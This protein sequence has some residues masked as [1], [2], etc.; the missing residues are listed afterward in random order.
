MQT[1]LP[2]AVRVLYYDKIGITKFHVIVTVVPRFVP[3]TVK[4]IKFE[5]LAC[6]CDIDIFNINFKYEY[7]AMA[8][9]ARVV[10]CQ[11]KKGWLKSNH[12]FRDKSNLLYLHVI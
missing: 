3:L 12:G 4:S 9:R 5:L 1:E 2:I 7:T 11:V 8:K 10:T 6:I